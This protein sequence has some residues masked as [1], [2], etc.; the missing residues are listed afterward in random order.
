MFTNTGNRS[1]WFCLG[2]LFV[3]AP[4]AG[5][6]RV[7][8][9]ANVEQL[10]SAVAAANRG[11]DAEIVLDDGEYRLNR[12]L[13]IQGARVAL[14][15]RS[16][17]RDRVVLTGNGMRRTSGVDNLISVRGQ[18]V[19]LTG[20][21]LQQAGN[22][23]VQV[24][25][26]FD[27]DY[28]QMR[29]CVL[30]DGYEQL[31]KVTGD[32]KSAKAA[33]NGLVEGSLFAYSADQAPNFYT[34]GIDLHAGARWRIEGN[35]FRNIASPGERTAE[36]AIHLWKRSSDA[37]ISG[38]FI[39]N[40]D[41]GIGLGMTE[42]LANGNSGGEVTGNVILHLRRG[43]PFSDVGIALESSSDT[44]VAG[45]F[46]YLAHDYPNAIEYRFPR[47]TGVTIA[48][49]VTNRSIAGRDGATAVVEGNQSAEG[50]GAAANYFSYAS[51]RLRELLGI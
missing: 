14:R 27:A 12:M 4:H 33:D 31:L 17:L 7:L 38:N 37:T 8:E 23:L 48:N 26:E 2:L 47:T 49:N 16:G 19:S 18:Y 44:L 10:Y 28:F 41:R 40:S 29:N 11:G 35:T 50:L 45:N 46:I 1:R 22:H 36:H 5:A 3:L 25:G 34:A 30:R 20:I 43:D 21:T 15:S 9:V 24:H 13:T 51:K 6:A 42:Q 39:I 32:A